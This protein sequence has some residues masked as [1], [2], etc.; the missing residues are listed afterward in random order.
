MNRPPLKL[1]HP[2]LITS[3]KRTYLLPF[4]SGSKNFR[5]V[6]SSLLEDENDT[7]NSYK[8]WRMKWNSLSA[9]CID[10]SVS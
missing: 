2:K 10:S 7:F 5:D 6:T 3:Q 8:F 9:C 1:K 4:P